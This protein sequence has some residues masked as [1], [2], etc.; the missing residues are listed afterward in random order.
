MRRTE[1]PPFA[2]KSKSGIGEGFVHIIRSN[3]RRTSTDDA[4]KSPTRKRH[5]HQRTPFKFHPSQYL[6][7][8]DIRILSSSSQTKGNQ[9]SCCTVSLAQHQEQAT[10]AMIRKANDLPGILPLP[11]MILVPAHPIPSSPFPYPS[12]SIQAITFSYPSF[13]LLPL[14]RVH[15]LLQQRHILGQPI[16]RVLQSLC[17]PSSSA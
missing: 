13:L 2:T 9:N 1:D 3:S 17:I 4:S 14:N 16:D 6:P 12:P 11:C 7:S 8:P 15:L 10:V 5:Q